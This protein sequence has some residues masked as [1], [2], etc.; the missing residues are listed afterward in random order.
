VVRD[1]LVIFAFTYLF[2]WVLTAHAEPQ[3]AL[4]YRNTLIREARAEWGLSAPV[5]VFAGQIEQES[6]WNPRACSAYACGLAQFTPATAA[7]IAP[8][9]NGNDVF[10]PAWS[11]RALVLYDHD[12]YGEVGFATRACDRW[13]FTLSAYNGGLGNVH[14]DQSLCRDTCDPSRWFGNVELQS[15]RTAIAF[16]ENRAYPETILFKRQL[17]YASWGETI[18]CQ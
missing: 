16:K 12:L 2:L 13:A 8:R 7:D 17:R 6:A 15:K 18:K 14:R 4:P 5:A 1:W 10:N 3:S 11:I 9:L